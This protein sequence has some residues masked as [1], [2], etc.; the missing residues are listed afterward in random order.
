MIDKQ[1]L[2]QTVADAIEG[3]DAFIVDINIAPGNIITVEIDSATGVDID[4]C[5]AITRRI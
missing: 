1:L 2:E 3:T 4:T 5:A